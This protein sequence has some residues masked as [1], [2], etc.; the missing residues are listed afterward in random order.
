MRTKG[1][2]KARGFGFVSFLDANDCLRAIKEM[3]GKYLGS[4]PITVRRSRWE[5]RQIE[6]VK[7]KETKKRKF[8]EAYGIA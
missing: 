8:N 7:E 6:K 5:E 2:N 4:R 3:N 1:E